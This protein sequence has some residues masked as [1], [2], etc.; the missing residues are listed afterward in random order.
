MSL[1][2]NAEVLGESLIR[3]SDGVSK[4]C[5]LPKECP[6]DDL[7]LATDAAI[8]TVQKEKREVASLTG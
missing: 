1:V 3:I 4:A 6:L 5:I 7:V 8:P 2:I